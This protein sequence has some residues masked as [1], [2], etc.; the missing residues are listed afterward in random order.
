MPL[1]LPTNARLPTT[2][3][4]EPDADTP[5]M[6]N[7]HFNLSFGTSDAVRPAAAAVCDREFC[8]STPHPFQAGPASAS[9]GTVPVSVTAAQ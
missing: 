1:R 9:R 7:A 8:A 4:C 2:V 5:G 3:I 6:P